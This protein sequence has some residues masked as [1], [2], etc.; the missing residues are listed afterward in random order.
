M[1]SYLIEQGEKGTMS[2]STVRKLRAFRWTLGL[3][4]TLL[5]LVVPAISLAQDQAPAESFEAKP[6]GSQ[7]KAGSVSA[8]GPS[9]LTSEQALQIEQATQEARIA[10]RKVELLEEQIVAKAKEPSSASADEKGFV[11]R[12]ADKAVWG[13]LP[14]GDVRSLIGVHLGRCDSAKGKWLLNGLCSSA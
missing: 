9:A 14:V 4:G 11:L 2:H 12:S 7:E 1:A 5:T 13:C 8:P 3:A 10:S 6:A